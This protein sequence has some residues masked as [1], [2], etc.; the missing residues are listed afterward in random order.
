MCAGASLAS[1]ASAVGDTP[2][3]GGSSTTRSG[4]SFQRARNASTSVLRGRL[5][6]P[7]RSCLQVRFQVAR[8]RRVGFDADDA[9]EAMRQGHREQA[10]AGKEIQR[11]PAARVA[12]HGSTSSSSRKRF[13]WKN[14]RW[15]TR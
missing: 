7:R 10:H 1:R 6:E 2:A 4:V 8:G 9:L 13:T 5:G 3:R 14:E 12:Q 15:P 11:Q